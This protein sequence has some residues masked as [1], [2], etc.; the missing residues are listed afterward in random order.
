MCI[1]DDCGM[2]ISMQI[3]DSMQ[4]TGPERQLLMSMAGAYWLELHPAG[5]VQGFDQALKDAACGYSHGLATEPRSVLSQPQMEEVK[6]QCG[7]H[8]KVVAQLPGKPIRLLPAT[9]HSVV[10]SP[11]VSD[12]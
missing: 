6:Q 8:V 7:Q 11:L 10:N 1:A 3:P 4:L 5:D 2:L 9:V 12:A